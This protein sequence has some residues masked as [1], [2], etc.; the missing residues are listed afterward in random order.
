VHSGHTS[1]MFRKNHWI[2]LYNCVFNDFGI[3]VNTISSLEGSKYNQLLTVK[4]D[5]IAA[6][7]KLLCLNNLSCGIFK[8]I[9]NQFNFIIFSSNK[10]LQSMNHSYIVK[11]KSSKTALWLSITEF[12][13]TKTSFPFLP[14]QNINLF[15]SIKVTLF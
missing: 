4:S 1:T 9:V 7:V 10:F 5:F 15:S 3:K 2:A 11:V 12:V 8:L 6:K 13:L 14:M